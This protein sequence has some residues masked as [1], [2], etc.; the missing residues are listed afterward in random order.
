MCL[1]GFVE[2]TE[3]KELKW[4]YCSTCK[5]Y[6]KSLPKN[7]IPSTV[8][9]FYIL[10]SLSP[11]NIWLNAWIL[12]L[13]NTKLF[14]FPHWWA[15]SEFSNICPIRSRCQFQGCCRLD[16]WSFLCNTGLRAPGSALLPAPSLSFE[17]PLTLGPGLGPR[18]S[19]YQVFSSGDPERAKK[20]RT[21]CHDTWPT[22]AFQIKAWFGLADHRFRRLFSWALV[23]LVGWGR[24]DHTTWLTGS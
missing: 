7:D 4:T 14:L 13:L 5:L 18:P 15:M 6:T 10:S 1:F 9:S 20:Y 22:S 21:H 23:F 24:I 2:T 11:R 17:S 3:V 16:V 19:D 12:N 8:R